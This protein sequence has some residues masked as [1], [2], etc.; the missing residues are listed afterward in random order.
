MKKF[1]LM[2]AL[3]TLFVI[4]GNAQSAPW[5][6]IDMEDVS[7]HGGNAEYDD[8]TTTVTFKGEKDRW[9]DLPGVSGDLT[10]H[11]KLNVTIKKSTCMLRFAI[12]YKDADGKTQQ[13]ICATCYKSMGKTIEKDTLLKIDL[14]D[15]GKIGEDVLKNVVSIR[16]A[17][18]KA[19]DGNEAPWDVQF[20]EVVMP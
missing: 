13:K 8:E 17:M 5:K 4:N 6:I 11:T 15:K 7:R 9:I 3:A 18:A 16:V 14:T 19:V 1:M 20:G 2:F 12:R 10:E